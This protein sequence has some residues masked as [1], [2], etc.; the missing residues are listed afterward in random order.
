MANR[1]QVEPYDF[2]PLESTPKR[3]PPVGHDRFAEGRHNGILECILTTKTPI[4]V[5]DSRFSRVDQGHEHVDFPVFA[6]VAVIPGSSLKGVIRTLVEAI[7]PCCFTLPS[8]FP[9][10]Y[11]LPKAFEHCEEK[12]KIAEDRFRPKGLC[13]ACRLFG[14]LDPDGNWAYAGNVSISDA[15]SASGQYT[16]GKHITLEVLSAPKPERRPKAYTLEDRRTVRGRKF[17]RHRY[18]DRVIER[19]LKDRNGRPR[20]DRQNKTVQ[21]VTEGSVFHFGVEYGNLDRD[22][23]SLLLY[24]LALE[25]GLWHKVGLGKPIGLGSVQIEVIKWTQ[26][27][28]HARYRALG[29]GMG[30]YLEGETLKQALE[31][32]LRIY[33]DRQ[34]E[35]LKKLRE[36]LRPD[37]TVDVR[38]VVPPPA[39]GRTSYG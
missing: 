5:Y 19:V 28:L 12:V 8:P 33:R 32:S 37:P 16:L 24:A 29:G 36:I 17:Y 38:Y 22:D 34:T 39:P 26:I 23:L 15:R 9:R 7:E 31:E 25:D 3:T 20:R 18:P 1:P 35:A 2:V 30:T 13:P 21:P 6:G 27:D 14:S 10:N 11:R 4:F